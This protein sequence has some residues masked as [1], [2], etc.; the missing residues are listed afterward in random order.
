M[1]NSSLSLLI[2]PSDSFLLSPIPPTTP[3]TPK[4][5]IGQF[6][7]NKGRA[8]GKNTPQ[9]TSTVRPCSSPSSGLQAFPHPIAWSFLLL[10]L[11]LCSSSSI[12]LVLSPPHLFGSFF[13]HIF[14]I[15]SLVYLSSYSSPLSIYP[16]LCLSISPF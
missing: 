13:L 12:F 10:F 11:C 2:F 6:E 1:S 9:T 3:L 5:G 14:P 7:A 4:L 8:R 16:R 15:S